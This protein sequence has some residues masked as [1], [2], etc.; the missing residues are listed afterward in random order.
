MLNEIAAG[1]QGNKIDTK[2]GETKPAYIPPAINQKAEKYI[3]GM[4]KGTSRWRKLYGNRWKYVMNSTANKM[5]TKEQVKMPPTYNDC[6]LY[7]SDAADE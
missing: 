1:S 6:L 2:S 5:A 7:T 3:R 4:K